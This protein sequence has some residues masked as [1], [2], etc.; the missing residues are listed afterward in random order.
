MKY[1][2]HVP[3]RNK[4]VMNWSLKCNAFKCLYV[5]TAVPF[6]LNQGLNSREHN[7]TTLFLISEGSVLIHVVGQESAAEDTGGVGLAVVAMKTLNVAEGLIADLQVPT[8]MANRGVVLSP[9]QDPEVGHKV[10]TDEP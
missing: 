3:G 9:Q 8:E 1:I 5:I 4:Q 2:V 7:M 6:D 10:Q